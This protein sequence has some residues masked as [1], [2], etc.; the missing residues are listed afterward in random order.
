MANPLDNYNVRNVADPAQVHDANLAQDPETLYVLMAQVSPIL[1]AQ[2]VSLRA[3]SHFLHQNLPL[4]EELV[5][6]VN[7]RIQLAGEVDANAAAIAGL[8]TH[9]D[10]NTQAIGELSQKVLALQRAG[11]VSPPVDTSGS[12]TYGLRNS[13]GATVGSDRT[14]VFPGLPATVG[15]RFPE[16]DAAGDVW[17]LQIPTGVTVQHIW[18]EG[19]VRTDEIATLWTYN[20]DDREYVFTGTVSPGLGGQYSI[21]LVASG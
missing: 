7:A 12:L 6:E 16:G 10:N 17:Y 15:V 5:A 19:L 18:N 8:R 14:A 9:T 4:A 1:Q 20:S 21:A 11:G 2:R 3:F 13:L